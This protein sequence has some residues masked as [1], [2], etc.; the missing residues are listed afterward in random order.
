MNS[1][2]ERMATYNQDINA[3]IR[4]FCDDKEPGTHQA[5]KDMFMD[6]AD[7]YNMKIPKDKYNAYFEIANNFLTKHGY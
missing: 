5:Y 6:E 1:E 4:K 7:P 2:H 3:R